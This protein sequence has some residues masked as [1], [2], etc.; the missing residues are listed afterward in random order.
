MTN[1]F[2]LGSTITFTINVTQGGVLTDPSSALITFTNAKGGD[3]P[4]LNQNMAKKT[5]GVWYYLW[6]SSEIGTFNVIYQVSDGVNIT[7]FKDQFSVI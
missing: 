1:Q 5:T 3:S 7:V 4:V 2:F 6:N